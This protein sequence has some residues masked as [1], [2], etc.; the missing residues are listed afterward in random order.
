MSCKRSVAGETAG[1]A[2]LA[3][4]ASIHELGARVADTLA[5]SVDDSSKLASLTEGGKRTDTGS[6][7]EVASR[8]DSR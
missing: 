2:V 3:D 8:T 7:R 4:T 1:V 5:V 6:T